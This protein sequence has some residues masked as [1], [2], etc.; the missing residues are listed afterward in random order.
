MTE[1]FFRAKFRQL[2]KQLCNSQDK[3]TALHLARTDDGELRCE[4]QSNTRTLWSWPKGWMG[5][6]PRPGSLDAT[7]APFGKFGQR[8]SIY[9][10]HFHDDGFVA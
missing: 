6:I 5:D 1:S 9:A 7:D 10:K 4:I 8:Y 2:T 3:P